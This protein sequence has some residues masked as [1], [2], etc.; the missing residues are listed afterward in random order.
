METTSE[1]YLEEDVFE[2][3]KIV[4]AYSADVSSICWVSEA[5]LEGLHLSCCV[6]ML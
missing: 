6:G 1:E 3:E 2:V 5:L 4:D